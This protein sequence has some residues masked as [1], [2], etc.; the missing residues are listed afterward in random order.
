MSKFEKLLTR[1]HSEPKDF[2]WAELEAVFKK[3]GFEEIQGNGSRVKFY[4]KG[5][6]LVCNLHKPHPDPTMKQYAI[7]QV[8]GFLEDNGYIKK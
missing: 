6:D 5:K 8:L 3:L 4:D 1:L 2:K 7:R